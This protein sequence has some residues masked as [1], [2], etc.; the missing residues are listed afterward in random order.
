M[1]SFFLNRKLSYVEKCGL[2]F[3]KVYIFF[4][5]EYVFKFVFSELYLEDWVLFLKNGSEE[6]V[7][8]CI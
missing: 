8:Y 3:V 2:V 1:I 4:F 6:C 5:F 7:V